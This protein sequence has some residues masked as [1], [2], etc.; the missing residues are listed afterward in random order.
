MFYLVQVNYESPLCYLGTDKLVK[1][2]SSLLMERHIILC[3]T[4]L[5]VLTQTVHALTALLYPFNW[6]HVYI[7]L[8]PCEMFD[9]VCAPMPFLVGVLSTFLPKI[10]QMEMEDVLI[11]DLDKKSIVRSY[12]DES[13][14]LPKKLQR[15]LKTAINMC[16][17][18][19][20]ANSAQWLMVMEAFLRM[21][22]ETI[23][24]Y[25]NHIRTQQDGNQ[26]FQ[27]EGFVLEPISRD[28]RQF[29][30]WFTETQMFEVFITNKLEGAKELDTQYFHQRLAEHKE[31]KENTRPQRGFKGKFKDFGKAL[32]T[33]FQ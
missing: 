26:I 32:K 20:E 19:K 30:E 15:A 16:K 1:V 2:F 13:T 5:S 6:P 31:C 23:G 25:D 14:I 18:D 9:V 24:H 27:K 21:F 11:I 4:H 7:P 29:L 17:I 28:M 12:G 22:M 33:K 10:L 3:S 8:L